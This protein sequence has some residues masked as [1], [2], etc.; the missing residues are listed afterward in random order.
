MISTSLVV[1]SDRFYEAA[2]LKA[3][4]TSLADSLDSARVI[5][6]ELP[7]TNWQSAFDSSLIF[8]SVN[9]LPPRR[10]VV[11]CITD[12]ELSEDDEAFM[13]R[14]HFVVC[15]AALSNVFRE[16]YSGHE[17]LEW[18][19]PTETELSNDLLGQATKRLKFSSDVSKS[20][21]KNCLVYGPWFQ[22]AFRYMD[23][24]GRRRPIRHAATRVSAKLRTSTSRAAKVLAADT[25]ALVLVARA[26]EQGAPVRY[27][28][29]SRRIYESFPGALSVVRSMSKGCTSQANE[30]RLA[31]D[32][33]SDALSSLKA[34][35]MH[36][37]PK[38]IVEVLS[39]GIDKQLTD[40]L[41]SDSTKSSN[42]FVRAAFGKTQEDAFDRFKKRITQIRDGSAF[43]EEF[44]PRLTIIV[45]I[46][47]NACDLISACLPSLLDNK[48]WPQ[49]ELILVDDGST[50]YSTVRILEILDGLPNVRLL[51]LTSGPSGSASRPRNEGID[52]ACADLVGFL[53]PDNRICHRGFDRLLLHMMNSSSDGQPNDFVSGY[54]LKYADTIARTACHVPS[55]CLQISDGLEFLGTQARFPTISTQAALI[56][57]KLLLDHDIRFVDGAVGQDTLF[58]W[59]V[60]AAST[61]TRLVSDVH[62]SY[63]SQRRASVTNTVTSDWFARA[64]IREQAQHDFLQES[65]LLEQYRRVHASQFIRN[66]YEAKLRQVP[67]HQLAEAE[68]H[69]IR[70]KE[71]YNCES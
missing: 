49:C 62:I 33:L 3:P 24:L 12:I 10:V 71:L 66:W 54:Q 8:A 1:G 23:N 56:R 50:D 16:R 59:Q 15:R 65:G 32:E 17:I 45:P 68:E 37:T 64:L 39:K 53:D 19:S 58:G 46:F 57:R 9:S 51:R 25:R 47:D 70:I 31:V 35:F 69:L 52:A 61:G 6:V 21:E 60:L 7:S 40:D 5:V 38:L 18:F 26:F 48:I 67:N 28:G 43:A 30:I 13:A 55:G 42:Y 20:K 44:R 36:S 2:N 11:S 34:K 29:Y 4:N 22:A 41:G 63:F 14:S 27:R